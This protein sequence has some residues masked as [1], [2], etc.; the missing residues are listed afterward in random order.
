MTRRLVLLHLRQQQIA[1][2]SLNIKPEKPLQHDP[3]L[4]RKLITGPEEP[5]QPY[6]I[7]LQGWVERGFGRGSKDLG[8]PT[9]TSYSLCFYPFNLPLDHPLGLSSSEREASDS[10]LT[11]NH[12]AHHLANLPDSSI[13]PYAATLS[14]GVHYGY[15]RVVQPSSSAPSAAADATTTTNHLSGDEDDKVWPMVMSIGWNPFYNNTTRTAVRSFFLCLY[16]MRSTF[17]WGSIPSSGR[18]LSLLTIAGTDSPLFNDSAGS[19]HITRLP[20]RLLRK[21]TEGSHAGVHSSRVQLRRPRFVSPTPFFSRSLSTPANSI[22]LFL[23][24]L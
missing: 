5:T 7:Y 14:T 6:P 22:E 21:R 20:P 23:Q 19:S 10:E 15:A 2:M 4:E 12:P 18:P 1:A 13:A 3:T 24:T 9:G 8:C 17:S 16:P 11:R